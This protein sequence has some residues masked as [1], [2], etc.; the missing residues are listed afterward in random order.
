MCS[1]K[2]AI[3]KQLASANVP[4]ILTDRGVVE[5]FEYN[6]FEWALTYPP[7]TDVAH[8]EESFGLAT[9]SFMIWQWE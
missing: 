4:L 2:T 5:S 8:C 3:S 7:L 6:S 9:F 1:S